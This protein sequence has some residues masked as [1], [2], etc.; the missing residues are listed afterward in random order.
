MLH[1]LQSQVKPNRGRS[2]HICLKAWCSCSK[3][4]FCQR[5]PLGAKGMWKILATMTAAVMEAVCYLLISGCFSNSISWACLLPL[6]PPAPM[7]ADSADYRILLALGMPAGPHQKLLSGTSLSFLHSSPSFPSSLSEFS[8]APY[9]SPEAKDETFRDLE[10]P[11]LSKVR[12][13]PG[14]TEGFLFKSMWSELSL[15]IFIRKEL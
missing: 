3:Q 9:V 7:K 2:S 4:S 12:N 15:A 6:L 14:E 1:P 5:P 8:W 13:K 11:I 10:I